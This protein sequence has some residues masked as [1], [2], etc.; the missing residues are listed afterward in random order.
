M[1]SIFSRPDFRFD[2]SQFAFLEMLCLDFE[3]DKCS[4]RK[5]LIEGMWDTSAVEMK[6]GLSVS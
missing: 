2:Q 1:V 6:T 3:K 5:M 4:M